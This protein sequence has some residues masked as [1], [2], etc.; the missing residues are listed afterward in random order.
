[1][2]DAERARRP[3]T[4]RNFRPIR[5]DI[6]PIGTETIKSDTPNDENRR[7][8][9]VGDAPSLRLRSGRTGT[10]IE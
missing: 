1:M 4:I 10:A 8:I 3:T 9:V 7:P 5:S 2:L 6:A